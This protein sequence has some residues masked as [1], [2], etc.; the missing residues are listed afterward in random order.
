MGGFP[1]LR[2]G[3]GVRWG[4]ARERGEGR[5]EGEETGIGIQTLFKSNCC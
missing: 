2:N 3:W 1:P 4:K 5:G